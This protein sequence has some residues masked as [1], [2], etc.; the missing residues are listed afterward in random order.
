MD[1]RSRHRRR[2]RLDRRHGRARRRPTTGRCRSLL[3]RQRR[4]RGPGRAFDRGFRARARALRRRRRPDRHARGR[5]DERP[6]RGRADAGPRPRGRRRRAGLAC[7]AAGALV[8]AG[9]HR[10]ALSRAAS[11]ADPPRRG[12]RRAHRLL[13]LPRLPRGD[14]APRLRGPRATRS[15]ARAASPAR[16]RSWPSSTASAPASRR[17]RSTW[18]PRAASARASCGSCPPWAA[19]RASWR[20]SSPTAG[21]A[22]HEPPAER[23]HRRRRPARPRPPRCAWSRPACAVTVYERD[24]Q[25]GGLAGTTHARRRS[26]STATTTSS[27]PRTTASA[28]WPRRSGW[29]TTRS[30]SAAPARASSRTAGWRRC[31][32][33]RELLTFPGLRAD[34]QGAPGRLRRRLPAQGHLRRPRG[35]RPGGLAAPTLRRAAVGARSGARCWTRSSTAASTTCPRPTCGR[36]AADGR[37]ARPLVAARSWATIEGGYQVLVD[38]L[39]GRDPR[40][41]AARS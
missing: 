2:R 28:R 24:A 10:V 13:V 31:R 30:A 11:F 40:R 36:A 41:T 14:P 1:R 12:A 21:S 18:T 27:C 8:G 17:S 25:L 9:R 22:P 39:G 38:R 19:T 23:R 3:V 29:A 20:A 5:H 4:N 34:G 6:R 7:T 26:P 32:R 35:P 15:S 37:H 33:P 16:P